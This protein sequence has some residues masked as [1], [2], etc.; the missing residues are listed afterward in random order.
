MFPYC[1]YDT[2]QC[3]MAF[4]GLFKDEADCWRVYLGWPTRGEVRHAKSKGLVCL[5][6]T[7]SWSEPCD[8]KAAKGP[9][10]GSEAK[11]RPSAP[12]ATGPA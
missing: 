2:R 11:D 10:D 1:I 3:R 9:G 7:V 12:T 8:A 4:L 6:C 5:P